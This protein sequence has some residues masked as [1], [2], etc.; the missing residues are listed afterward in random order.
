MSDCFGKIMKCFPK[1]SGHIVYDQMFLMINRLPE[2][3]LS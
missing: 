3:D 1:V 2:K